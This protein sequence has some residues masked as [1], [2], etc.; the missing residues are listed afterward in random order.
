M[1]TSPIPDG[2]RLVHVSVAGELRL[3]GAEDARGE[4]GPAV[5]RA[6]YDFLHARKVLVRYFPSHPL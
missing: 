2:P 6:A 1:R 5:A 4:T 3:H